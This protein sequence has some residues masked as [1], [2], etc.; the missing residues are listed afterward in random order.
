METLTP[1]DFKGRINQK[2]FW[3]IPCTTS[4]HR[5]V[6]DVVMSHVK[7][8]PEAPVEYEAI[9]IRVRKNTLHDYGPGFT[10]QGIRLRMEEAASLWKAL[11]H[12]LGYMNEEE[13]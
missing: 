7:S 5:N 4:K 12:F 2:V 10:H 11:G 3:R 6:A 13:E 9:D 8:K 1:D